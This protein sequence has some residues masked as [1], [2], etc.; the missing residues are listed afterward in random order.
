MKG[1]P[2]INRQPFL[3]QDSIFTWETHNPVAFDLDTNR[4]KL[5]KNIQLL[6]SDPDNSNTV[7]LED[8]SRDAFRQRLHQPDMPLG[9]NPTNKKHHSLI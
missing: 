5:F 8:A 2:D 7:I 3:F 4:I 1:L 6:N 9:D